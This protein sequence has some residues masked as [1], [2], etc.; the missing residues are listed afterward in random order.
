VWQTAAPAWIPDVVRDPNFPRARLADAEG[1]HG[2]CGFPIVLDQRVLGVVEFFSRAVRPP[3]P[4]L[5]RMMAAI[6]SQLGQFLERMRAEE[7]RNVADRR[8]DEFLAMLAHEL[9]N[10]LAPIRNAA[11]LVGAQASTNPELRWASQMIERQV[12]QMTRLIDDLLDVSRITRGRITLRRERLDL[13]TVA[14]GAVEASRAMVTN[15][16][17]EF[18]VSI[19][20]ERFPVDGDATRLSQVLHNLINNAARYTDPGGRIELALAREGGGA[21]IRVLDNGIGVAP[22]MR[23]A[24]FE[25]FTQAQPPPAGAEGGLGIGLTLVRRLVE[26]HGGAVAAHS[27]GIGKGS[28]FV[29]RLPLAP[30]VAGAGPGAT[31]TPGFATPAHRRIIVVD[32]N[33][34]SAESLAELLRLRG[35]ETHVAHDGIEALRM[36]SDL[37]PDVA[38]LDLGLPKLSGYEVAER[39]R[40]QD[41]GGGIV[42]IALT[43]WGQEEDRRRSRDSGFDFHMTKPIEFSALLQLLAATAPTAGGAVTRAP[44][45]G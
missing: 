39:I 1:L 36:V 35:N 13:A 18:R 32:D 19:P 33:R 34:D 24:I 17:H 40:G 42:L 38:L 14:V 5:I 22:D 7:A 8:K 44:A 43:G 9:R 23:G 28:E 30:E 4:D 26:L 6:G 10:P 25:L 2:A 31:S 20:D 11:Q 3:D 45:G 27:E 16:G 29:V 12:Q 37:R 41:S 15:A 21:V